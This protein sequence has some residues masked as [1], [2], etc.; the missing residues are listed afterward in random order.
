[1]RGVGGGEDNARRLSEYIGGLRAV[2]RG[3]PSRDGKPNLSVIA[4]A[5]GFDRGVFYTNQAAKMLLDGA[6][7]ELGL[8][9]GLPPAGTAFDEARIR[10]EV[11]AKA[12]RRTKELEEEVLRLRAENARLKS[13]NERF[14]A[15]R[16]LM[17]ETGRMP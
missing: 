9:N 1:M 2:Q 13:E 16:T 14:K 6:T 11:K 17:A 8:D 4:E 5:C 12:D 10:E 15:I 7:A 3:L